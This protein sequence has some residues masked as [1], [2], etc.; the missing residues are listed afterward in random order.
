MWVRL[1]C[2]SVAKSTC[3]FEGLRLDSEDPHGALLLPQA[4]GMD[5]VYMHAYRQSTHI[6]KS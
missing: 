4:P 2:G 6:Y 3:S 5:V 1:E